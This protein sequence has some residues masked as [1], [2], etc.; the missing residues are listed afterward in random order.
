MYV[1]GVTVLL[2]GIADAR[3]YCQDKHAGGWK[4]LGNTCQITCSTIVTAIEKLK[5]SDYDH[6]IEETFKNKINVSNNDI[7]NIGQELILNNIERKSYPIC[8][9]NDTRTHLVLYNTYHRL[10]SD[11]H[12]PAALEKLAGK[13]T[14]RLTAECENTKSYKTS[15]DFYKKFY[16]EK[17]RRK[18]S[19]RADVLAHF[20]KFLNRHADLKY[21]FDDKMTR[22]ILETVDRDQTRRLN[23]DFTNVIPHMKT[24]LRYHEARINK[25]LIRLKGTMCLTIY[26]PGCYCKV[27]YV[28]NHGQCVKPEV[29]ISKEMNEEYL[30]RIILY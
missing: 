30:E 16:Q 18:L 23:L 27:G 9:H 25:K 5:I 15:D 21:Q 10:L 24:A 12:F 29:C 19:K 6:L 20:K 14:V 8:S 22:E 11:E 4:P 7:Y 28:E 1:I 3:V 17:C 26:L 2:F 13:M